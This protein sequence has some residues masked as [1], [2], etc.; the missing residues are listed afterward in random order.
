MSYMVFNTTEM[1]LIAAGISIVT[2][3]ICLMV[4]R[5]V[6]L[7]KK[8]ATI[9]KERYNAID[10]KEKRDQDRIRFLEIASEIGAR[11]AR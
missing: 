8:R 7:W 10:E 3:L 9:K 6:K 2:I 11:T 4:Q 5:I 1:S